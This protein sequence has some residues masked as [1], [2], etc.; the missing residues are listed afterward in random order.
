M[1]FVTVLIFSCAAIVEHQRQSEAIRALQAHCN[2]NRAEMDLMRQDMQA[3]K[4]ENHH[5][6][7]QM[8]RSGGGSYPPAPPPGGPPSS[9]YADPYASSRT[10]LPPLRSLG[11]GPLPPAPESMTGVQYDNSAPPP[12]PYRTE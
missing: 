2:A 8:S 7:M 5:L 10:E 12:Q 6:R 9:T 11:A 3:L 4:A 1:G